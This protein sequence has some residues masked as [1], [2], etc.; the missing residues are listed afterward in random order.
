MGKT[1]KD[2]LGTIL[3]VK[4]GQRKIKRNLRA[5]NE[6][7]YGK[8]WHKKATGMDSRGGGGLKCLRP[9]HL[10]GMRRSNRGFRRTK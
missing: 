8:V 2:V 5:V 9:T 3:R 6:N 1:V 10:S 4:K 7:D